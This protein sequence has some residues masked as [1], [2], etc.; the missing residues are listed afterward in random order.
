MTN[1]KEEEFAESITQDLMDNGYI[2]EDSFEGVKVRL[3][4]MLF[5]TD[6]IKIEVL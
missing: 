4:D 2:S 3:I 5:N 6:R 1:K